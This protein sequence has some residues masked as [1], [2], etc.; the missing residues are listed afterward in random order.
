[1][2]SA[3]NA[4]LSYEGYLLGHVGWFGT[5]AGTAVAAHLRA[6]RTRPY[7]RQTGP[8]RDDAVDPR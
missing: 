1:V 7:G 6:R 8:R 5:A 3:A 4:D 2:G